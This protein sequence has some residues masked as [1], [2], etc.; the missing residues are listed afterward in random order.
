MESACVIGGCWVG[1]HLIDKKLAGQRLKQE[2]ERLALTQAEVAEKISTTPINVSRWELGK[3]APTPF[4]RRELCALFDRKPSWLFPF[5]EA[6]QEATAYLD[7]VD[8]IFRFNTP[9]TDACEFYDRRGA[10][11][12][13]FRRLKLQSSVSVV[14]PRRIGK[15]WLLSYLQLVVR[16]YLGA[17]YRI[18]YVDAS[19]ACCT[20]LD[21]FTA[22]ML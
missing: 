21:R 19:S 20:T 10:L 2:R 16:E 6:I 14:G 12:P 1:E 3:T 18:G 7:S 9:L 22:S 15:T 13:L 4:F 17:S 8:A 11:I 5:L